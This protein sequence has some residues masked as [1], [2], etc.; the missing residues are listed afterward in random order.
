MKGKLVVNIKNA[1]VNGCQWALGQARSAGVAVKSAVAAVVLG[2]AALTSGNLAAHY[3]AGKPVAGQMVAAAGLAGQQVMGSPVMRAVGDVL[4]P[5]S[6]SAQYAIV[7]SDS[8]GNITFSP[9]Q[10]VT[11][12]ITGVIAC[13]ISAASL[14]LLWIGVKWLYKVLHGSR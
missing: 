5:A 7:T 10:L 14:V 8:S 13:V 6:A 1:V 3:D 9:S 11:P 4:S 12:V 2:G